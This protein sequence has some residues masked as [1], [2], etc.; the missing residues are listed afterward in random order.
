MATYGVAGQRLWS[1]LATEADP[2]SLTVLIIEACRVADRLDEL[3]AVLS[4]NV[5]AW[6]RLT[7]DRRGDI[8][9]RVDGALVEARQQ[10]VVLTRL[11]SEIRRVRGGLG[12]SDPDDD[13][14]ADL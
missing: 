4:G 2:Y 14:L 9:V 1:S 5:D 11:L 8:E 6:L 12:D 3:S 7:E 13:G 10:A